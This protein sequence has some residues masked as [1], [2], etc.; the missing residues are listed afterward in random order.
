M[1]RGP[2]YLPHRQHIALA[3]VCAG[4]TSS[5]THAGILFRDRKRKKVRLLDFHLDG[6]V[7]VVDIDAPPEMA[8]AIPELDELELGEVSAYCKSMAMARPVPHLHY[9]FSITEATHL[10]E[11]GGTYSLANAQGLTCSTFVL[12]VFQTLKLPLLLLPSWPLRPD[13]ES[14]QRSLLGLLSRLRQRLSITI[15]QLINARAQLPCRRYRPEEV[16]AACVVG[17]HPTHFDQAAPAGTDFLMWLDGK[18]PG[19]RPT[20]P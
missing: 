14:A 8:W 13:D 6:C 16:A 3:A 4:R 11:T 19:V 18:T 20:G 2:F 12:A 1:S 9:F 15:H 17:G 10:V 7:H 5:G